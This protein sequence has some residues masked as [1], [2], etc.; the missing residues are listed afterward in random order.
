[1]ARP[2][3]STLRRIL[4]AVAR[5]VVYVAGMVL[6]FLVASIASS[7]GGSFTT[8]FFGVFLGLGLMLAA[9]ICWVAAIKSSKG[10]HWT[11]GYI[12]GWAVFFLIGYVTSTIEDGQPIRVSDNAVNWGLA[13]LG[14]VLLPHP[15]CGSDLLS[16]ATDRHRE[17]G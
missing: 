16:A 5:A 15:A 6:G 7:F 8:D 13:A 3:V 1:M 17:V 14:R 2:W 4:V 11:L 10:D 12:G 9:P